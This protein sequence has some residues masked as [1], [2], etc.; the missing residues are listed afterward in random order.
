MADN[1]NSS[2]FAD[3]LLSIRQRLVEELELPPQRVLILGRKGKPLVFPAEYY[4]ALRS[5]GWTPYSGGGRAY[6]DPLH[7][8]V[9]AVD[10]LT[11]CALDTAAEE[12]ISLT[13]EDSGH[14]DREEA[15]VD[16][17][18]EWMPLSLPFSSDST[19]LA[20]EPLHLTNPA[21]DPDRLSPEGFLAS[22][23]Y[24]DVRY[25]SPATCR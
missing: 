19:K 23:V 4:L 14:F 21:E 17:L 15:V 11:R 25:K 10:V 9:L 7:H 16:T 3:I 6:F 1:R 13:R 24:F 12:L 22:T 18:S 5:V 8:R 2:R 20:I